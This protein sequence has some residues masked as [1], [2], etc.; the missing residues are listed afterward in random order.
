MAA[1]M[2]LAFVLVG[3][4]PALRAD[5]KSSVEQIRNELLPQGNTPSGLFGDGAHS[6]PLTWHEDSVAPVPDF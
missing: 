4:Q 5:A 1:V 3:A 6:L 2:G